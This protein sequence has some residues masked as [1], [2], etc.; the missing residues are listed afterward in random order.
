VP[1]RFAWLLLAG[2]L[3]LSCSGPPAA[4]P[5]ASA[6]GEWREFEGNWSATGSRRTLMLDPGHQASIFSLSGSLLLTGGQQLGVGF[7]AEIIGLADSRTGG[8]GRAVW[9]DERGD[10]VF[11]ELRGSALATGAQVTATI[12]G[13]TGRYAGVTGEYELRWRWVVQS[14]EGMIGGRTESLKGRAKLATA[15]ASR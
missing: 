10:Q 9:P 11:S 12:T 3:E 4:P 6:A 15:A 7:R 1:Y 5:P 13:G 14:E 8:V 2:L